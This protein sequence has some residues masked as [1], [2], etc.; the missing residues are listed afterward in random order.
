[1][2]TSHVMNRRR[3][4]RGRLSTSEEGEDRLAVRRWGRALH[5]IEC[6]CESSDRTSLTEAPDG[7]YDLRIGHRKERVQLRWFD[8]QTAEIGRKKLARARLAA[9]SRSCSRCAS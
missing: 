9:F 4:A 5:G 7:S 3:S 6:Q 2:D 1:M 8:A